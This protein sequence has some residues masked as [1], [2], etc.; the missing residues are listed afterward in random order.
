LNRRK[1][2]SSDAES[3]SA[4]KTVFDCPS[5]VAALSVARHV[6]VSS[7]AARRNTAARSSQRQL[8]HSR[9]TRFDAAIASCTCSGPAACQS[10]SACVWS[11]GMTAW[12]VR[13]V[14]IS[15]PPMT[16]GMSMRSAAIVFSRSF[17]AARSAEP[18]R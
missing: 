11:C 8:A 18:G 9:A 4:W 16:T 2:I 12:C 3:I 6:V 1:S 15:R 17:S 13:P 7:S 10:A 14:R 5:I